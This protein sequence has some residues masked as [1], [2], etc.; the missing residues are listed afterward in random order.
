MRPVDDP[1]TSNSE[2]ASAAG[3]RH[4]M[5]RSLPRSPRKMSWLLAVSVVLALFP[6]ATPKGFGAPPLDEC[7]KAVLSHAKVA[8]LRLS[9]SASVH[10]GNVRVKYTV[11]NFGPCAAHQTTLTVLL[12]TDYVFVK[13]DSLKRVWTCAPSGATV[14]CTLES[15]L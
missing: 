5:K 2:R 7:E 12:P 13:A 11:S 10:S 4:Q 8:N 9:Q 6:F 1:V 3:R 14:T 15:T